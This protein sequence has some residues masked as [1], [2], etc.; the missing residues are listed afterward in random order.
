MTMREVKRYPFA[1]TNNARERSTENCPNNNVAV[2]ESVRNMTV[3][4]IGTNTSIL[5]NG[6]R[7]NG[8]AAKNRT[9]KSSA[10][11]SAARFCA[12]LGGRE[13]ISDGWLSGMGP[14]SLLAAG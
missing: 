3:A 4:T 14:L 7:A 10:T 1:S 13:E 6:T 12:R 11:T 8:S 5:G 2:S 9:N